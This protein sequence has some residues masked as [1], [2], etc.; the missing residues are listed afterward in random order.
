MFKASALH[1]ACGGILILLLSVFL[2]GGCF[3][4]WPQVKEGAVHAL[5]QYFC[6]SPKKADEVAAK[7]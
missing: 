4:W 1:K 2:F 6:S 7:S 3:V 5:K